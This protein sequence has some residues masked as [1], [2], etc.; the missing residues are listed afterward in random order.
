MDGLS[1]ALSV[2][3]L[4]SQA[5]GVTQLLH[6]YCT[7]VKS[8]LKDAKNL[9]QEAETLGKVL[10]QLE[11]F[12]NED[13]NGTHFH[14][15]ASVLACTVDACRATLSDLETGLKASGKDGVGKIM[16]RLMW[17]FRKQQVQNM[18]ECLKRYNQIFQFSLSIE[19]W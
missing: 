7:D 6:G 12:L 15:T 10:K 17:P 9:A 19:G 3:G 4:A 11:M 13:S 14:Q 5:L 2:A 1:I 8:A 18:V 16:G